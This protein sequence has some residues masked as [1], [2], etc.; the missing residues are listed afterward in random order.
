VAEIKGSRE[1]GG[2]QGKSPRVGCSKSREVVKSRGVKTTV[3]SRSREDR[4]IRASS[5]V[6]RIRRFGG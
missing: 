3:R 2:S 5:H 6:S 1:L 4:W